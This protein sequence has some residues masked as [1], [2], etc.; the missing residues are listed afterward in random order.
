MQVEGQLGDHLLCLLSPG[1]TTDARVI[2]RREVE[3]LNPACDNKRPIHVICCKLHISA[4]LIDSFKVTKEGHHY[5]TVSLVSSGALRAV[6]CCFAVVAQPAF[7]RHLFIVCIQL[8]SILLAK[9]VLV[10]KGQ[11]PGLSVVQA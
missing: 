6:G 7:R 8:D 5:V 10:N 2:E 4:V 3:Q 9:Q 1:K 11:G